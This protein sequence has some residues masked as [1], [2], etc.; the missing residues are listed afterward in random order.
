MEFS[1]FARWN[2]KLFFVLKRDTAPL[3]AYSRIGTWYMSV[4]QKGLLMQ[5]WVSKLSHQADFRKA[6]HTVNTC[7]YW[8]CNCTFDLICHRCMLH[9]PT[10]YILPLLLGQ[11][12]QALVHSNPSRLD[13]VVI[14]CT[15]H[16]V[17][18]KQP[19]NQFKPVQQQVLRAYFPDIKTV[20]HRLAFIHW[21]LKL[22]AAF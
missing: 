6:N 19:M 9:L 1:N 17:L 22:S 15:V 21:F 20:S 18:P 3:S 12:D 8:V 5:D 10:V 7:T 4:E 11:W 14:E 13:W 2:W 16:V